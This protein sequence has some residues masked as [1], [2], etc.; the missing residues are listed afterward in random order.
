LVIAFER[1]ERMTDAVAADTKRVNTPVDYGPV[2]A[3]R[4]LGLA[5][6]QFE[7][8]IRRGLIPYAGPGGR[9]PAEVIEDAAGRLPEILAAVGD[10]PPVGANRA[11]E[12]LSERLQTDIDRAE[13]DAVAEQGLLPAAGEYKGWPLY[14]AVDLDNLAATHAAGDPGLEV[15]GDVAV[16]C[17]MVTLS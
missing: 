9:W 2:Q 3:P 5:G 1:T 6:W 10:Q 16:P 11:A 12:R 4:R 15:F 13:V 14:D 7:A 8:A 17:H